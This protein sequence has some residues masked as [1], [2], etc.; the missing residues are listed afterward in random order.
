MRQEDVRFVS[1]GCPIAGTFT[2]VTAPVAAALLITGSGRLNRDSDARLARTRV[3][4]ELADA[5]AGAQVASL[6]YD[7]RGTGASGGDYYRAGMTERLADA[8]AGLGWLAARAAGLPLLV[9]GH[10]EGS[11]YAA[12][13]AATDAG[14]AGAVLVS[15]PARS[16][17]QVINYQIAMMATRLPPAAGVILRLTRTDF[18]RSQ[19]KRLARLKASSGDVIRIQG[20]RVNARWWRDFLGYDPSAALARITVPVL[21]ITGGQDVQVPPGDVDAIG[22]LVRGPFEG[23]VVGD[24]SHL[25]RPDPASAGPR[26]Y[27]RALRQPVS[28]EVLKIITGWVAAHWG[29]RLTGAAQAAD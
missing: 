22:R 21:A 9:A 1:N 28:P 27:R 26:G 5:L 24:L 4:R 10:S 16:G 11:Y 6:R 18:A 2:Q 14:V 17:E 29:Q 19:R 23:H 7:K 12:E 3:T 20:V 15:A 13:L 25:L 8:R